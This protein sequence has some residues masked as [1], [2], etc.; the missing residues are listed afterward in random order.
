VIE[1]TEAG[2]GFGEGFGTPRAEKQAHGEV[3]L[4]GRRAGAAD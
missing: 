2:A 1:C 4:V 3:T